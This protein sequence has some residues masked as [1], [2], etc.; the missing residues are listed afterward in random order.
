MSSFRKEIVWCALQDLRV[1]YVW[2]GNDPDFDGGLDCSGAVLFWARQ[3][4][5]DLPDMTANDLR[6][7][8]KP[9]INPQPGDLCFYGKKGKITHV[10]MVLGK[11]YIIGANGGGPPDAGESR[12]Q[13][14][15]RMRQRNARVKIQFGYRYR[16]DFVSFGQLPYKES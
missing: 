5:L 12:E 7:I 1:P 16:G 14:A 8:C 4:G 10:V 9:V 13:Y 3:S 6:E 2:G 11:N 15:E